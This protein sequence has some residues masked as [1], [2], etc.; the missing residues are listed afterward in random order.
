M[1][2]AKAKAEMLEAAAK[3]EYQLLTPPQSIE[4][5]QHQTSALTE[6]YGGN[7]VTQTPDIHPGH[8][9][10]Q[11]E[12]TANT[13]NSVT[14]S[15]PNAAPFMTSHSPVRQP[16]MDNG[17]AKTHENQGEMPQ[18]EISDLEFLEL[19]QHRL[20]RGQATW[21]PHQATSTVDAPRKTC[22]FR[23]FPHDSKHCNED[24]KPFQPHY[25]HSL[26][27]H[28]TSLSN[29]TA[30]TDLGKYLMQRELVSSGF[31]KFD[32]KPEDYWAWK[33]SFL[34]STDDLK[35]SAREELDLLCKWLG[36]SS[37]EQAKRIRAVNIHNPSAGLK[38]L[39]RKLEDVSG[40]PEVIENALLKKVEDFPKISAKEN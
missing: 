5:M 28:N 8:P 30:A 33:A 1:A 34:S 26:H 39:W 18:S 14:G 13:I 24:F 23:D 31:W 32:D 12:I 3:E 37:S 27:V 15:Q 40:S 6:M 11:R 19:A 4:N 38:I 29:T 22:G 7:A 36:P 2:A 16:T 25:A 20:F 10:Y 35:L 21:I 9:S 17:E